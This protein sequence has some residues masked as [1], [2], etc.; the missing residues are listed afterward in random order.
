MV[1]F[2]Q[3]INQSPNTSPNDQHLFAKAIKSTTAKFAPTT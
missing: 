2:S 1:S 3:S